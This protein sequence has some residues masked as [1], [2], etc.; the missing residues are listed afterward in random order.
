[1]INQLNMSLFQHIVIKKQ[2][3]SHT[4]EVRKAYAL[5]SAYVL[6]ENIL[7]LVVY[8]FDTEVDV[9]VL[10]HISENSLSEIESGGAALAV[11][12]NADIP[13]STVSKR[14]KDG[15]FYTPR[16][17]TTYIVENT[18]GRLCSDKKTKLTLDGAE[19]FFD[20]KRAKAE[21]KKMLSFNTDLQTKR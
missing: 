11:T 17:I 9:T 4:E 15:V 21:R 1:M 8:D 2:I 6:K 5:Y 3:A 14:K 18:L 10:G 7:K 20:R 19:Y 12:R 13:V 16:Y